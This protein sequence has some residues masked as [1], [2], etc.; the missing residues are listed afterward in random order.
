VSSASD[1]LAA[2][3]LLFAVLGVVFGVWYQEITTAIAVKV[4]AHKPD[5]EPAMSLV[6]GVLRTKALPLAFLSM[7]VFL[8]FL[9]DAID[10]A[11]RV[12]SHLRASGL[13]RISHY[14]SVSVALVVVSFMSAL[15]AA[16][17][18][19]LLLSLWSVRR[20]LRA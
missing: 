11:S 18:G 14:D 5:R 8:T 10:V 3:S 7:L 13:A 17:T 4:E 20:K 9:P 16:Y 1:T 6:K 12:I 15:L 2:E 19:M